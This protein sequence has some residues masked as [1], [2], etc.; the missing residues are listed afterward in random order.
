MTH[1]RRRLIIR[2]EPFLT[3]CLLIFPSKA[4]EWEVFSMRTDS[5]AAAIIDKPLAI[6]I[7]GRFGHMLISKRRVLM[8]HFRV[9]GLFQ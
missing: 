2:I 3:E 7:P 6:P 5:S 4:K 1:A 9:F 8:D